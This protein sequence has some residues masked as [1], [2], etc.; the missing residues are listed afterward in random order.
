MLAKTLEYASGSSD[1]NLKL[2]FPLILF[3]KENILV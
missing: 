3:S 1:I 2:F